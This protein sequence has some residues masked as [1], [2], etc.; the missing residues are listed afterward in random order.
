S[1]PN[2]LFDIDLLTNI[3]N[4]EPV[5]TGNQTNKNSGIKDNVDAVPTQQYIMLPLLYDNP[6]SSK[7]AVVNDTGK[8]TNED[9]TKDDDKSGQGKATNTNIQ[10]N[11]FEST[12]GQEKD[13]NGNNIYRM[14]TPVNAAG[15]SY[16]NLGGSIPVNAATLPTADT[17]TDPPMPN[18]EDT[19]DLLNTCIFSSA[20][21]DEDVGAAADLNNLE[22]TMNVNHIPTTRI[23]KDHPKEKIIGDPLSSPQ[24]RRI[25]KYAQEHAMHAIG[26]K[27]VYRNK[28]DKRGI[29][30]RNKARLVAQGYTQEEGIDYNEVF[31]LV[32]RIEAIRLFLAYTS[33]MGFIVYQMDVK[34]AFLYGTIEEEVYVDD[35][36][37]GST[38]K[39]LCTEFESLMHKKFQMSSIGE[40][41]F[42][43]GLHVMQ[44]DDGIFISQDKYVAD[45]LKK[46]DFVTMKTAS[47]LIET[48]KSL[49]KD[50][51]DENVD[52]HLY[53]SM[54][55]SLMYLTA[56]RP[57]I[58]FAVC[59]CARDSPF[60]LEAF[61][62]SDYA[63][64]SL[65]RKS[66]TGGCQFL[67]KRLIS[68]QC[69]KQTIVANSTTEAEYVATANCCGQVLWIQNQMLDYGF[70]FMNTKIYIDN[71]STICIVKNPVFHSK[72]KHI[73]IKHH[74]I[75]DSYEKKLIQVIKIHTDHNVADFLTKAFDVNMKAKWTTKISQSSGPIPLVTDENVIKEWED[76]MERAATT[77][78][79]LEIVPR[80]H[81]RGAEAQTRFEVASKQS[82]DLPISR[83][84]TL[85]SGEDNMKLKEL[86]EFYT[87]MS[88]RALDL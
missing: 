14:F 1:G 44:R 39:S 35:I 87:K 6:Q 84:N 18:L 51:E 27:Y 37:F 23:Y 58:M 13:A 82:N 88:E 16:D 40:L 47:T 59:A 80:Y 45:I 53:R 8:T 30:V 11:E 41:T 85:E 73:K 43:L 22:T 54:I 42:F 29:V 34:S 36:I 56:S 68:W 63:G 70:N 74:F 76:R 86:M 33:F 83:V 62:D 46:F 72:T 4:Y 25:K 77:A 50:E 49:L 24:T 78:S 71:E 26:T 5:T 48:H 79:S 32:A 69:K 38:K 64:A 17:R 21:D 28:K 60:D 57:D 61:S 9:P 67:G 75:R 19:T 55:G 2:W 31:A 15:S 65:D 12:F 20:Y 52:F 81:I 10:R 7:D 66:T 3:V